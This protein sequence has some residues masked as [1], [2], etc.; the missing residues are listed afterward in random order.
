MHGV[1]G[2]PDL[3][4]RAV[5]QAIVDGE[6]DGAERRVRFGNL[7]M[8]VSQGYSIPREITREFRGGLPSDY[9]YKDRDKDADTY[10]FRPELSDNSPVTASDWAIFAGTA[11]CSDDQK[12]SAIARIQPLADTVYGILKTTSS[13]VVTIR[14]ITGI[15]ARADITVS[16]QT[17]AGL[18]SYIENIDPR[19][20]CV[21]GRDMVVRGVFK[22]DIETVAEPVP[23]ATVDAW[24]ADAIPYMRIKADGAF[25]VSALVEKLRRRGRYLPPAIVAALPSRLSRFDGISVN[26]N[27]IYTWNRQD[28]TLPDPAAEEDTP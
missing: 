7:V 1:D 8:T 23:T 19:F 14:S 4:R 2:M 28:L 27:G 13:G 15:L 21:E 12:L 17:Y 22:G 9:R 20:V 26:S 5:D 24:V 6:V 16:T 10:G 18:R 3:V 25:T 11:R